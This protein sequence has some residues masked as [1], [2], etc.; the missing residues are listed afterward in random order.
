MSGSSF[1]CQV[2]VDVGQTHGVDL[3]PGT[4]PGNAQADSH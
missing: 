4:A 2:R 1:G 3:P